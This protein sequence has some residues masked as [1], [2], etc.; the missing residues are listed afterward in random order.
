MPRPSPPPCRGEAPRNPPIG[1]LVST[2]ALTTQE[3]VLPLTISLTTH[4]T[5]LG[6]WGL[7]CLPCLFGENAGELYADENEKGECFLACCLY[8]AC[9]PFYP[10]K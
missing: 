1:I 2:T 5:P 3:Y 6:V 4:A 10:C 8:G 9:L 7:C